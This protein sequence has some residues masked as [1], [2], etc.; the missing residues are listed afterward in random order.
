MFLRTMFTR[1]V[2]S[3][4]QRNHTVYNPISAAGRKTIATGKFLHIATSSL[5][6]R[7][8]FKS[9]FSNNLTH[10]S[11]NLPF[12]GIAN[13]H[14]PLNSS[15]ISPDNH[16]KISPCCRYLNLSTMKMKWP[17]SGVSNGNFEVSV[18]FTRNLK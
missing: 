14:L 1:Y 7:T 2:D 15:S 11:Y 13:K 5:F 3:R 12:F 8:Y 17:I 9:I 4:S 16:H 6:L 18:I 10:F